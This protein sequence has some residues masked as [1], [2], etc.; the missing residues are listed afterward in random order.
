[1]V[2]DLEYTLVRM[3]AEETQWVV[4][5]GLD[6][7]ATWLAKDL[8]GHALGIEAVENAIEFRRSSAHCSRRH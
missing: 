5:L 7:H 6:G 3:A 4:N 2:E 8:P 1:M